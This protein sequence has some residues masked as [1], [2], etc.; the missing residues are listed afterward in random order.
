MKEAAHVAE[1]A[2]TG[3]DESTRRWRLL[4][5]VTGVFGLVSFVL[6]LGPPSSPRLVKSPDSPATRPPC[7]TSSDPRM[8]QA[9]HSA[10]T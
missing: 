4:S 6:V 7:R 8:T 1:A 3:L 10:T 2:S 9:R 5:R